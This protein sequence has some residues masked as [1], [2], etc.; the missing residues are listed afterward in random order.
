MNHQIS[1]IPSENSIV[2]QKSIAKQSK[3]KKNAGP[4]RIQ[5]HIILIR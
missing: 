1:K 3:K 2:L 4:E 5:V